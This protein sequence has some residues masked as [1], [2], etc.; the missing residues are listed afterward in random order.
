MMAVTEQSG[1]FIMNTIIKAVEGLW[2]QLSYEEQAN[3]TLAQDIAKAELKAMG[4]CSSTIRETLNV[5]ALQ[6]ATLL[7]ESRIT[8]GEDTLTINQYKERVSF[9]LNECLEYGIIQYTKALELLHDNVNGDELYAM[10]CAIGDYI[11]LN[12]KEEENA[13]KNI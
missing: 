3:I 6:L 9:L 4:I 10:E 7:L 11:Y 5:V 8:V 13:K 12:K 2:S 1:G